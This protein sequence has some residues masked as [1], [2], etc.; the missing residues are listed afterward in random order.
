MEKQKI[1]VI[2]FL[3][4]LF[5]ISTIS[6]TTV[7]IV[8]SGSTVI[9][10]SQASDSNYNS[11][12]V[13]ASL[14]VVKDNPIIELSDVNKTFNDEDFSLSA[15][16]SSTGTISYSSNDAS[17]ATISGTTVT[18]V[19]AGS[20][21]IEASQAAD[22]NYNSTTVTASITVEKDDPVISGFNA[23]TKTYLDSDFNLSAT[24]ISTGAITYNSNDNSVATISGTTVAI[25]GAG[26]TS[27]TLTQIAD[28][29]YNTIRETVLLTVE[30]AIPSLTTS[31]VSKTFASDDF[32]V[33]ST[34]VSS[35]SNGA[36]SYSSN[37]SSV[38]TV[39]GSTIEI[40][41]GGSAVITVSQ[42]A[43]ANFTSATASFTLS[44][45]KIEPTIGFKDVSKTYGDADFNLSPTTNSTGAINYSS[46]DTNVARVSGDKV[47]IIGVGSTTITLDQVADANYLAARTSMVLTVAK[48]VI[49]VSGITANTKIYDGTTIASIDTSNVIFNGIVSE[50]Q[51][52]ITTTGVFDTADAG[53]AK[54]V[55][56]TSTYSG[57]VLANYSI[58]DQATTTASITQKTVQL[59][60]LAKV[61]KVYDGTTMMPTNNVGYGSL[62]GLISGDMVS[63]VGSPKFDSAQAGERIVL[64]GT[65]AISGANASNYKL[66]WTNGSGTITKKT[67]Y[68][69][70]NNDA[71]FVTTTDD[72]NFRGAIIAGFVPGESKS[73]LSGTLEVVRTNADV[74][75]ANT[76]DGVLQP[77]GYISNNYNIEYFNGAFTILPAD[78]L[79]LEIEV[80]DTTYSNT[81][82]YG[83]TG[84]YLS[85]TTS[86]VIYLNSPIYD[87]ETQRY[88]IYDGA[89]GSASFGIS[90]VSVLGPSSRPQNIMSKSGNII[91]GT[92]QLAVSDVEIISNNF[93]E[94]IT[95]LGA[96]TVIPKI[97]TPYASG[98]T[99]NYDGTRTIKNTLIALSGVV[100]GDDVKTTFTGLYDQ[101]DSGTNLGYLIDDIV[102][103]GDDV[104]SY[105]LSTSAFRGTD[106]VINK[107]P[108]A[109]TGDSM[110]KVYDGQVNSTFTQSF[111]GFIDGEDQTDLTGT[112]VRT[113]EG[114]TAT[115]IG[116]YSYTLSGYTSLNYSISY[117]GGSVN[118][119]K[120]AITVSGIK[121]N[122][123]VYDGTTTASVETS[124][125]VFDG[126]VPG[127]L[128]TATSTA[129]F[130]TAK[131]G[132]D[133][134]VVLRT[135]YTGTT[136]DNYMITDQPS[137]K[138]SI[139]KA[140]LTVTFNS[141][142]S[143]YLGVPYTNFS[144]SY[145]GFVNGET[146]AVLGGSLN[147]AGP[148]TSAT[149]MGIYSVSVSG[150]T[151][152]NY[153]INYA[154]GSLTITDADTDLD[155][156]G[157]SE[158]PDIDGDGILN[159]VDVDINGD[160]INDNGTDSNGDGINDAND[161]DIDGDGY[162]NTN[163]AFP[164]DASEW[165][166]T[167]GDGIGN[168]SDTDDDNDKQL[169]VD[170]IACGSDPLDDT[171]LSLDT[172]GDHIP[173]CVDTDDDGDTVLDTEDA[174]PLIPEEWLDTDNDGIGNNTDTDDDN[175]GQL[176]VD[177]LAC[178]SD[179]LNAN[180]LALDTDAD[181]IP[182]CVDTDDDNDG[183]S[184]EQE[185]ELGTSPILVD[186][187]NDGVRDQTEVEDQTDPLDSCSLVVNHQTES[188][189]IAAWEQ[190]DCDGDGVHN[191]YEFSYTTTARELTIYPLDTDG[192]GIYDYLDKDDDGDGL[193]TMYEFV[194]PN[195]DGNP[196]DAPDYDS[197]GV[198]DYLDDDDEGDGTPTI[199]EGADPNG[200]GNP[201]DAYDFDSDGIKNY[202]DGD[203]D[204]DGL[205]S[206]D[207]LLY[208]TDI[209]DVD[210]DKDGVID[211]TEVVDG[212]NPTD[213]CSLVYEHQT[214][215]LTIWNQQDCDGDGVNN[216]IEAG[217]D[218]DNDGVLDYLDPDDDGDGLD[219]N[220]ENPSSNTE[221]AFDS[222]YDGI[223]DYLDSNNFTPS[224]TVADDIE[225]YNA[226]S[227]NG[228]G[229]N[230]VFTIRNIE[231]YP[232]NELVIFN[233]WGK[234]IYRQKGYGTYSRFYNG[235][236]IN[237]QSLPVGTYYYVL[238]VNTG[239][240]E[241]SF[242]G[243]LYINR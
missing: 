188:A 232:D 87:E 16:S 90:A 82:Q 236:D 43:T 152:D 241:E 93:N 226:M 141:V 6:G 83:I 28:S 197:D 131:V 215:D 117:S 202:L 160:G 124:S 33:D 55:I 230:D 37:N 79:L 122:N 148:G 127:E 155:G 192:D 22:S 139:T 191:I 149:S 166:D 8:G 220:L 109:V 234:E 4:L 184:D 222:D 66:S 71:K 212:T 86:E 224:S 179:P 70:A 169:D 199:E 112:V 113:G 134:T 57:T 14:T 56:L 126:L 44:V 53:T 156:I 72:A 211:G 214:E 227:P 201:E 42:V 26:T 138:A 111:D 171:S 13:T 19:G 162:S 61:T 205:S 174:F 5:L 178:N 45:A 17:V 181:S 62:A 233:R 69:I 21:V 41:G 228:D 193:W 15:T 49:T 54:E 154:P 105:A 170:E 121:A 194:D 63:V 164:L 1:I 198:P 209:Y 200:D 20:A 125:V 180:E 27:I 30:K 189:G 142:T 58:T 217:L 153:E 175:D 103:G 84:S 46:S 135:S 130:T 161:P 23:L 73:D 106:G 137:T 145:D 183:L 132:T 100:E 221:E 213:S 133:I 159:E 235:V 140:P 239:T 99:K 68:V 50:D 97:I 216:G 24:S 64:Q 34:T 65:V 76:Y 158:D 36:F 240:K 9:T 25:V 89:G 94:E 238:R 38:A 150:L 177:E 101:K 185:A 207:E 146:S 206:E 51:I 187:D 229:Y 208:G 237:G 165:V 104:V 108:L 167:D 163:D 204:N 195:K 12:T 75:I 151:S 176:D 225:I 29:N 74:E 210:S 88:M 107:I 223:P 144:V 116:T 11:A 98:P 190:S 40:K 31:N 128:A 129:T 182:N 95:T 81:P 186:T 32:V 168:N 59:T 91:A 115:T 203:D 110:T 119:S 123:K 60:G 80:P 47:S 219:T 173:N 39:N 243:F 3:Q 67:L 35:N 120:A 85:S 78:H 172:D 157:D 102:L 52:T 218:S 143:A 147:F 196:E 2:I 242:K 10:A 96:I 48:K 92:Y 77:S 114:T 7:S 118:I 136:L 231:K 18:I